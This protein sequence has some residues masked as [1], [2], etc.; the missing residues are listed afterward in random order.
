MRLVDD[1]QRSGARERADGVEEP[2]LGEDDPDVRE[3]RLGEHGC[4]VAVGELA[5]DR[6][7]VVELDDP[8]RHRRIDGWADVARLATARPSAVETTN[9]SSTEP[10]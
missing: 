5:L 10:W 7:G 9:V 1:Q 3:R 6:V 4:Y 2:G 8:R